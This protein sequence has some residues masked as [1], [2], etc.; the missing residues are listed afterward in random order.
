MTSA[1][2]L[3]VLRSR[4][5]RAAVQAEIERSIV[6]G[7]LPPGAALREAALASRLGVSRGPVRE[8]L[9]ALEEKGLVT[10]VKHC[11]ASVRRIDADEADEIYD[12]RR[13]LE[14]AI[15]E[16]VTARIDGEGL[17]CLRAI[18]DAM[19]PAAGAR[20][21]DRYASLNL[22]FHDALARLTGNA[23]L[24]ETYSRL[25]AELALLRRHVHAHEPG[26]LARSLAEHRAIV[27]A[28]A[29]GRADDASRRLVEHAMR[30][31]ARLAGAI[32][33]NARRP[34]T[35]GEVEVAQTA[36]EP[37]PVHRGSIR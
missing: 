17:A 18:V 35:E 31:R 30:S 2:A 34:R 11:G 15:G 21:V 26:A 36:G 3:D 10:V 22:A 24:H 23:R 7:E 12:V 27:D 29:A 8:A 14:A 25:V 19:A 1:Q 37:C 9:R 28:I 32:G 4:S 13:V 33:A 20:D 16:R 6:D 5:L